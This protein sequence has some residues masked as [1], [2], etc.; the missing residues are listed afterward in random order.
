MCAMPT[1]CVVCTAIVTITVVGSHPTPHFYLHM[2]AFAFFFKL[3]MPGSLVLQGCS[4]KPEMEGRCSP[5]HPR[6]ILWQM[7]QPTTPLIVG[8][9][10]P[11]YSIRA[12]AVSCLCRIML[13]ET[14]ATLITHSTQAMLDQ[15]RRCL[16]PGGALLLVES[17]G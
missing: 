5:T 2:P 14:F 4:P 8:G 16:C 13:L 6:I 11:R 15:A 12:R 1:S 3:Y 17:L 7:E 10:C 9:M